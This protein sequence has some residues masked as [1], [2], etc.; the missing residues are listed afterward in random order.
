MV[1]YIGETATA[2]S[3]STRKLPFGRS[4]P[5]STRLPRGQEAESGNE[6]RLGRCTA[7]KSALGPRD[8]CSWTT[9][10]WWSHQ[11]TEACCGVYLHQIW[12]KRSW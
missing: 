9:K 3:G 2:W 1:E 10:A 6:V 8:R 12:R 4:P 5:W 11:A 7:T